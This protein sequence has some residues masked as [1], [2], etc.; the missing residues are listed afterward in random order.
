M[1][2]QAAGQIIR[3]AR[4]SQGWTQRELALRAGIDFSYV[5]KIETARVEY[6]PKADVLD[7]LVQQLVLSATDQ[8][9]LRRYYGQE[10]QSEW[11]PSTVLLPDY[12]G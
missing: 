9:K 2:F 5:S 12:A 3:T 7:V 10:P 4:L 1:D 6:A 11:C 8:S